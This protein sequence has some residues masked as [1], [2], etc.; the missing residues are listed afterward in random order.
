MIGP[1]MTLSLS[2]SLMS[3]SIAN[4]TRPIVLYVHNN[5]VKAIIYA[6]SMTSSLH[7]EHLSAYQLRF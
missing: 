4:Y 3:L 7:R 1:L 2:Y 6:C 5:F